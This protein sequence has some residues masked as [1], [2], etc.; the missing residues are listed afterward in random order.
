[1][2]TEFR[3]KVCICI[4]VN[5]IE[6]W[7]LADEQVLSEILHYKVK[8]INKPEQILYAK[9]ELKDIF[10]KAGKMYLTK[11]ANKLHQKLII[12]IVQKKCP[13][14]TAFCKLLRTTD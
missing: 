8:E 13:S 6:A 9:E 10:R 11:V 2:S 3:K 7:L 14:F 12:N 4:I 5:E 1:M